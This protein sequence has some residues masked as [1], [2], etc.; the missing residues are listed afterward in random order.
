M[1]K[2]LLLLLLL[3]LNSL[4]LA[5]ES[6]HVE[7]SAKVEPADI[8]AG[9][10]GQI[11]I[12]AKPNEGY[13][14]YAKDVEAGIPTSIS[15]VEGKG[16]S[17]AGEPLYPKGKIYFDAGFEMDLE[18]YEGEINF[19]I[20]ITLAP[21]ATGALT[22]QALAKS[23][24]CNDTG[25]DLP[26]EDPLNV[27]ITV[28]PGDPR[29]EGSYQLTA[30]D[31][32]GASGSGTPEKQ[33]PAKDTFAQD[34]AKAKSSG[35][36]GFMLFSFTLGLAALLTPCVFPM[37]PITVSFFS[38][39][40]GEDKKINYSGAA[41]YCAGIIGTFTAL[42]LI[43]TLAVGASGI[44]ALANNVWVNALIFLIFVALAMSL[45][46][47]FEIRPPSGLINRLGAHSK[48]AG[49]VGPVVMGLTFSL[50]SFTCTVPLVGTILAGAA[51]GESLLY[52]IMGMLAF[53]TAFSIPFFFL[54]IF[55]NLM[56][57]MPRSG[58]W[59]EQIKIF[60]GFLELAAALKF[61]SNIDL[62]YSLG[63]LTSEVFL[64]IWFGLMAVCGLQMLGALRLGSQHMEGQIGWVRRGFGV[65]S[66]A[67]AVYCLAGIQGAPMG[68]V[69]AFLPPDPYP[70]RASAKADAIPW[71]HT[72][73]EGLEA[74]KAA[75]KPMFI[76][77]TGVNCTNCRWMEKNMF[78]RDEVRK[79]ITSYVP[80]ELYTDRGTEEDLKNQ[81]LMKKLSNSVTLPVYVLVGPDEKVIRV[82]QGLT[83]DE[84]EYLAFLRSGMDSKVAAK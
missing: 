29:P 72:Y 48:A 4:A 83:R 30:I 40:K 81:E 5:G 35:L 54:A 18:K 20:P 44:N 1:V 50:T 13:H 55:P 60:M 15:L 10:K 78:T 6:L 52:P 11:L 3:L 84:A 65:A 7:W 66:L 67:I 12:T 21:D 69:A 32:G 41:A 8:R 75:G 51:S 24:A 62:I 63:W 77:F 59:M 64:A 9:E 76:D 43:V 47:I 19:A 45:F 34:F 73:A 71:K 56:S 39:K 37:I 16:Y 23:Q 68:E 46:G 61:L 58:A 33:D 31:S 80:V 49:F 22:I 26:A 28:S 70:G 82:F 38:K 25:C 36:L 2:G 42:G 27:N 74:A 57:S 79:L 17:A 53:S 14:I